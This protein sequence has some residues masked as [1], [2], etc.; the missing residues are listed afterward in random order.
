V[1]DDI[2][3]QAARVGQPGRNDEMGTEKMFHDGIL[4]LRIS[5]EA[6]EPVY[7][8]IAENI[9]AL[10]EKMPGARGVALPPERVLCGHFGVSR[11]TLRQ[12]LE[13]L[14]RQGWIRVVHGRGTFVA[15]KPLEKQQ[16][17]FRSFSEE[18]AERGA[19]TSSRLV[20]FSIQRP[21]PEDQTFFNI[22]EHDLTYRIER[23]RIADG[24]PLALEIA[25][26]PVN[27]FPDLARFDFES[28]S[29]Y[30]TLESEY[31]V[32]LARAVEEIAA[33]LPDVHQRK[34]LEVPRQAAILMIERKTYS[35]ADL[36]VELTTAA[37]RGDL[38][39]AIVRSSRSRRNP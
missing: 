22:G 17:E 1:Y 28:R 3:Q 14:E 7:T 34:L 10:I 4:R 9:R 25:R 19:R 15:G 31:G 24:V 12:G 30:Q 32:R 29:L 39:R 18:I 16:Q 21:T 35:E 20:S 26:L 33:V 2:V 13:Q 8:Q 36:P 37:F 11:M 27:R 5:K 38:Y 6:S 23:L